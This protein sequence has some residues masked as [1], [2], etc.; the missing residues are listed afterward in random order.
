MSGG[1][2]NGEWNDALEKHCNVHARNCAV[3]EYVHWRTTD[4]SRVTKGCPSWTYSERVEVWRPSIPKDKIET[5]RRPHSTASQPPAPMTRG[6]SLLP[7]V[8]SVP[9]SHMKGRDTGVVHT[10]MRGSCKSVTPRSVRP[11]PV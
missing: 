5:G 4:I 6:M 11:E 7:D 8:K 9:I 1:S 10:H 3:P 2:D